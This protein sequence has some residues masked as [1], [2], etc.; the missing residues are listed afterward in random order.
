MLSATGLA[1]DDTMPRLE[2][3]SGSASRK[4]IKVTLIAGMA[5]EV[6]GKG[7]AVAFCDPTCKTDIRTGKI[8]AISPDSS[9]S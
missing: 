4:K 5:F 9:S 3:H 7:D 2:S 6:L 8:P 1:R